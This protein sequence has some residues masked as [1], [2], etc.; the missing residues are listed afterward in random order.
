[1][2]R[3]WL[4]WL[5]AATTFV[6]SNAHAS[7]SCLDVAELDKTE[8]L[9]GALVL[10]VGCE[11][12][13]AEI[14]GE[15]WGD[16]PE[17]AQLML[18]TRYMV[19]GT[20][21]TIWSDPELAEKIGDGSSL[22]QRLLAYEYSS[23]A[24]EMMDIWNRVAPDGS[25]ESVFE[26][27]YFG[28]QYYFSQTTNNVSWAPPS[29][30]ITS[31]MAT[32]NV[33]LFAVTYARMMQDAQWVVGAEDTFL[34]IYD[35]HIESIPDAAW[36]KADFYMGKIA[37]GDNTF[38]EFSAD[39]VDL[40]RSG[41][42]RG[43]HLSMKTMADTLNRGDIV[44]I[45]ESEATTIYQ[46]LAQF[47]W[48]DS[49]VAFGE[50]LINGWGV[51]VNES[52]GWDWVR[53]GAAAGSAYGYDLLFEKAL[54]DVDFTEA[55]H[56]ALK[57]AEMGYVKFSSKGYVAAKA[58]LA[59]LE[60]KSAEQLK[61]NDYLRFHCETNVSVEDKSECKSLGGDL[62][63][64]RSRPSLVE[65]A[66]DPSILRF[67]DEFELDTGRYIALVVANDEYEFWDS[68]ETPRRDAELVGSIL[69][70]Q[71]GF[72][73]TYL[74]NASR[75][76]TLRALYDMGSDIQFNDHFLLYYAGHGVVD[77]AT[78]T[79]YWIP[80]N[81]SR[82]FRPDWISS[83]EIMTSLKAIPSRHLLLV[84][85]SCYSGKL[86]RGAAPTEGNPGVAVIQRLFSKKARVAITSGGDEPVQDASS[87]GQH[88]VFANAF[89]RA[90][91]DADGPTPSSTIFNDVL[92]AVS[93]EA[94]QTPQYAD[95]RELGHDGGDFIFVPGAGQ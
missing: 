7:V 36:L 62:K 91:N 12:V 38:R 2:S 57:N 34:P 69:E 37:Y 60:L 21:L 3:C 11:T 50:Q 9:E 16:F 86:L 52:V 14:L 73:V 51:P 31:L 64:F 74:K 32:S 75:R 95:M 26:E 29:T 53:S 28:R 30:R 8:K 23:D 40:L 71:Y 76:D 81:A 27:A 19:P 45:D 43:F 59:N 13:S 22:M 49:Q 54:E 65:A 44:D 1:M 56:W 55:I 20:T 63:A 10:L 46:R 87:G 77:R 25:W 70:S 66:E 83:A 78:D 79:A 72:E 68:L 39:V 33:P 92:G 93:L 4:I 41:V 82:D 61:L 42:D 48:P 94:S 35:D 15:R 80:S 89:A 47:G 17:A 88:S 85:D 5:L 67:V 6:A 18:A 84:A 58:L 90:L 24:P